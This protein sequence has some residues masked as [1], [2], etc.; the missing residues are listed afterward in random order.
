MDIV[1]NLDVETAP[2]KNMKKLVKV[3]YY[4]YDTDQVVEK[5]CIDIIF[6]QED[7][8]TFAFTPVDDPPR[9]YKSVVIDRPLIKIYQN[10][11]RVRII[12]KGYQ[13]MKSGGSW[14]TQTT[15][16]VTYNYED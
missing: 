16:D 8:T 5:N 6:D 7:D 2:M 13:Y 14:E 1:V 15:I 12:V 9:I 11:R 3:S 10:D 4:D